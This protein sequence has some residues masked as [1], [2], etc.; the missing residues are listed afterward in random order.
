M[1]AALKHIKDLSWYHWC[2]FAI[3]FVRIYQLS[4]GN[5]LIPKFA[6]EAIRT[7]DG[8]FIGYTYQDGW[9]Y[10][11]SRGL[12]AMLCFVAFKHTKYPAFLFA[13]VLAILKI[14]D[15]QTSPF[16]FSVGEGIGWAIA[17]LIT[18][19]YSQNKN[20]FKLK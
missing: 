9:Y 4:F 18:V 17:A 6:H 19:A 10:V 12:E 5:E 7:W 14:F 3:P 15:E 13:T 8:K 11:W 20:F 1:K 16:Y 2:C